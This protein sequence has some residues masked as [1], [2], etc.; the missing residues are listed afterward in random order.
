MPPD[1]RSLSRLSTSLDTGAPRGRRR[2]VAVRRGPGP[3]RRRP[4]VP[5][6][7]AALVAV[8]LV[9]ALWLAVTARIQSDPQ[10]T[11][12]GQTDSAAAP[13]RPDGQDAD[14][15]SRT[16]A[17]ATRDTT[18]A[19]VGELRL[20]LP[21]PEPTLVAFGE[22]TRS[23]ALAMQ[24]VGRLV[25]SDNDR[26]ERVRDRKGPA[27]HVL[28]SQGRPRAPTSAADVVVPAEA[29]VSAPVSGTVVEVRDYAMQGGVRDW[30][31]VIEA[32]GRPDLHVVVVH[33]NTP[34]VAVGDAVTA[35]ETP[36]GAVR[37]LPFSRAVDDLLEH[38]Q[39]HVHV[40]VR[41]AVPPGPADPNEPAAVPDPHLVR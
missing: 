2:R 31:V 16:Q 19:R 8:A 41:P 4:R 32:V 21:Y 38:R 26:F 22:G 36:L 20:V 23:E 40:E 18:F 3:A 9:A 37:Q 27:Y 17:R 30:R 28:A 1:L 24:P 6:G 13:A 5:R 12:A 11:A 29:S 33:L 25:G 7:L 14:R 10:V 15:P 34:A 39:P 35:G